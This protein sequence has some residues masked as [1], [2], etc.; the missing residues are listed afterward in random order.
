MKKFILPML[1]TLA[2]ATPAMANEGRIEA[3][4]GVVWFCDG[5]DAQDVWG[6]AAGYDFDMGDKAFAGVEVAGDKIGTS[7]TKVV[8]S[9]GG[10]AGLKAGEKGKVYVNG[11]WS[12][13][14][15]DGF[16][17]DP[18]AGVGYEQGFGKNLYA[19]VEYRHTFV[20]A[21]DD[22]NAVAVGLGLRF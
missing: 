6:M 18:Y 14:P 21:F 1:A 5:C 10:R 12:T 11:G 20:D 7:G 16:T 17:G 19:K 4:G 9:F 8:F 15:I 22:Q 3:R 2:V 13:E